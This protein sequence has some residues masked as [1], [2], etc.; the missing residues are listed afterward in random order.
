MDFFISLA[1]IALNRSSQ[2]LCKSPVS[3][4]GWATCL[5]PHA[6]ALLPDFVIR[7]A[8]TRGGGA[9]T[10]K[11]QMSISRLALTLADAP[12]KGDGRRWDI[13]KNVSSFYMWFT[14]SVNSLGGEGGYTTLASQFSCVSSSYQGQTYSPIQIKFIFKLCQPEQPEG[15]IPTRHWRSSSDRVNAV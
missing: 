13:R 15:Y 3:W 8:N 14:F 4:L 6:S 1:N 10:Q 9:N 7:R 2:N 12:H 11:C 5:C